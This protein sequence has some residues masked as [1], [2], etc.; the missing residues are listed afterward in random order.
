MQDFRSFFGWDKNRSTH[1]LAG[2]GAAPKHFRDLSG[3]STMPFAKKLLIS[4][5]QAQNKGAFA[6]PYRQL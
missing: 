4:D 6:A 5:T 1:V 3:I 2:G